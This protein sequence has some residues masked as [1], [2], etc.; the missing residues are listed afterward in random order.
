MDNVRTESKGTQKDSYAAGDDEL[1][2]GHKMWMKN[3][4][5]STERGCGYLRRLSDFSSPGNK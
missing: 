5:S 3:I 2:L 1:D 4:G